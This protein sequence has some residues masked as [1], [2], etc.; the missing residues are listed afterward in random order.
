MRLKRILL[1]LTAFV[2]AL[3]SALPAGAEAFTIPTGSTKSCRKNEAPVN[4]WWPNGGN[5]SNETSYKAVDM[6]VDQYGYV[7]VIVQNGDQLKASSYSIKIID[8]TT[9]ELKRSISASAAGVVDVT[10]TG[11]FPISSIRRMGDCMV[12]RGGNSWGTT[13]QKVY[14]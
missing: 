11:S 14:I 10:N 12:A 13:E 1:S 6:A 3:S 7:W 8:G 9:F 4:A 5:S 2:L